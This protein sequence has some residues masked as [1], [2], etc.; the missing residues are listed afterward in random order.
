MEAEQIKIQNT[1]AS[2]INKTPIYS[3]HGNLLSNLKKTDYIQKDMS[4]LAKRDDRFDVDRCLNASAEYL[5]EINT[6]SVTKQMTKEGANRSDHEKRMYALNGYN[7][8]PSRFKVDFWP[9]GDDDHP[10]MK[11]IRRSL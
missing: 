8:G 7:K 9:K 3:K 1:T 5:Y 6:Y 4:Q 2:K 11:N 10:H